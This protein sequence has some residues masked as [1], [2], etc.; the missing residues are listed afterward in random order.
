VR[1]RQYIL[2]FIVS[3]HVLGFG[4]EVRAD[5][6]ILADTVELILQTEVGKLN[7]A[8]LKQL[9]T[10]LA[11]LKPWERLGLKENATPQEVQSRF[12]KLAMRVHEDRFSVNQERVAAGKLFML[13]NE[14]KEHLED[15]NKLEHFRKTGRY[16]G[17]RQERRATTQQTQTT[18]RQSRAGSSAESSQNS[19][20]EVLI[21]NI[22]QHLLRM[23]LRAKT[24]D[25]YRQ[26]VLWTLHDPLHKSNLVYRSALVRYIN[27]TIHPYITS[28]SDFDSVLAL[29]EISPNIQTSILITKKSKTLIRTADQA[30]DYAY[31][32][33]RLFPKDVDGHPKLGA[34]IISVSSNL[35][36]QWDVLMRMAER[37]REDILEETWT[38]ENQRFASLLLEF[39]TQ[40]P[41]MNS[42]LMIYYFSSLPQRAPPASLAKTLQ[43]SLET[44]IQSSGQLQHAAEEY[45]T[46]EALK[47]MFPHLY[48]SRLQAFGNTCASLLGRGRL[49]GRAPKPRN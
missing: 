43:D 42:I 45:F 34:E 20:N 23:P 2:S 1:T 16:W 18:P 8:Q 7:E 47:K 6:A 38:P 24:A 29:T 49:W 22:Y 10:R 21:E 33:A 13:I 35:K 36:K 40:H 14:A 46:K 3:I 25:D 32:L 11:P 48:Q 19:R 31:T 44:L 28:A 5:D 9:S 27:A 39:S 37:L 12:R 15:P 26:W 30:Y 17:S 41:S 4:I